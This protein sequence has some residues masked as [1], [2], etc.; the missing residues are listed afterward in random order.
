MTTAL[1][2]LEL[3]KGISVTDERFPPDRLR[4]SQSARD[5]LL[6]LK[7]RTG[8]RHWN[9]LCR[10]AFCRSLAEPSPPPQIDPPADSAVE[11]T[12]QVF[13]GSA[14][15]VYAAALRYRCLIDGLDDDP[16]TLNA[17]LRFHL[18]RGVGYLVA[19]SRI[20][21]ISGLLTTALAEGK[22]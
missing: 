2:P 7:R 1:K 14:A 11:M 19:D 3:R 22:E 15:D 6:T 10:W 8:I 13:G 4:L 9:V 16:P 5:Q 12:W 18:H 20:R 21:D 17:Q